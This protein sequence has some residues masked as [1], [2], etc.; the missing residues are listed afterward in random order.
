MANTFFY[1]LR[2]FARVLALVAAILLATLLILNFAVLRYR[3]AWY[4]QDLLATATLEGHDN[5]HFKSFAI[6]GATLIDGN[7]GPP[8][9]NSAVLVCG[10]RICKV[11]KAGE[12]PIPPVARQ[13]DAKG[14][15]ILPGLIDMH[16][17]L[18]KGDSLQLFLAAGVT[19]VRDLANSTDWVRHF[20]QLTD[21]NEIVGPRIFYAGE[22]LDRLN[23]NTT[24]AQVVAE[25]QKR[26]DNGASVIKIVNDTRPD[27]V[28]AAVQEA[29]RRNTPVTA[30]LLGNL[31]VSAGQGIQL[32]LDGIEHL[33]GVPRSI[34]ADSD[35]PLSRPVDALFGWLD[36]DEK[37][38]AD[39]VAEIARRGTYMTPTFAMLEAVS[40]VPRV[41]DSALPYVIPRLRWFWTASDYLSTFDFTRRTAFA[42]HYTSSRAFI[43]K[44]AAAG[45][46]II[47][48]TDTPVPGVVPGYALHRELELL[49]NAGLTP[50]GAIQAATR[51]AAECLG[52]S[53]DL[54]T[55]EPGK[56]ADLIVTGGTPSTHI[57][58][59]RRLELVF[60][61]GV[62]F[63]PSR[64]L[65][66]TAGAKD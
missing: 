32:G 52:R 3:R 58:D 4:R 64:I 28:A 54:G 6:V 31:T 37:K 27:L 49:A 51:T 62:L 36:K 19:T 63:E 25:V 47:A 48:G 38:E 30:D 26:I 11:G 12:F 66:A 53:G 61:G 34:R 22:A 23:G 16:V 59:I 55:V 41:N 9:E 18:N 15:F 20:R 14:R 33:S 10:E 13:I 50:M 40:R 43:A 45:G 5:N 57:S 42:V 21:T 29:H 7:G 2:L 1:L 56:L 39:L 60:K 17:H 24:A 35:L 46:R 44:V 65:R 8:L